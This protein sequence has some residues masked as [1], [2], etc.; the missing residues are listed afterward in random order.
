MQDPR[1]AIGTSSSSLSHEQERNT[2]SLS[3]PTIDSV[4]DPVD[5]TLT[6]NATHSSAI[7][8]HTSTK[9]THNN[10]NNNDEQVQHITPSDEK[11][12][13]PLGVPGTNS[14]DPNQDKTTQP[15]VASKRPQLLV[16]PNGAV[17]QVLAAAATDTDTDADADAGTSSEC[18]QPH[19]NS[20]VI[21]SEREAEAKKAAEA[22]VAAAIGD[23]KE[24]GH[25]R[26]KYSMKLQTGSILI[27][28]VQ[29]AGDTFHDIEF[30]AP[31][32]DEFFDGTDP[33]NDSS[34]GPSSAR[35]A[36]PD[37]SGDSRRMKSLSPGPSVAFDDY[38]ISAGATNITANSQNPDASDDFASRK[39]AASRASVRRIR[40]GASFMRAQSAFTRTIFERGTIFFRDLNL[41]T[42]FRRRLLRHARVKS[43]WMCMMLTLVMVIALATDVGMYHDE[44]SEITL[45]IA[46][47]STYL[48]CVAITF[49]LAR[50]GSV[51]RTDR[52][53]HAIH[54]REFVVYSIALLICGCLVAVYTIAPADSLN[55]MIIPSCFI[56]YLVV[57]HL[58]SKLLFP[59]LMAST[60]LSVVFFCAHA[61][62]HQPS[63]D[64]DWNVTAQCLFVVVVNGVLSY[65]SHDF[66]IYRRRSYVLRKAMEHERQVL[67]EEAYELREEV[68]NLVLEKFDIPADEAHGGDVDLQSPVEKAMLILMDLSRDESVSHIVSSQLKKVITYLG[69]SNDIFR[70]Q[71][72]EEIQDKHLHLDADTHH[73]LQ[74]LLDTDQER[75]RQSV[76]QRENGSPYGSTSSPAQPKNK[77]RTK[78]TFLATMMDD[79][80]KK[81]LE[82][83]ESLD[84]WDFDVFELCDLT[85]QRPLLFVGVALMKKYNLLETFDIPSRAVQNFF[86][87][88]EDGYRDNPYHNRIHAADVAQTLHYFLQFDRS[89]MQFTSLEI[90]AAIVAAAVHDYDHPGRNNNFFINTQHELALTYNDRSVLENHHVAAA[91]KILVKPENNLLVNCP[92]QMVEFRKTVVDMVLSTDLGQHFDFLGH[93]KNSMNTGTLDASVAKDRLV[94]LKMMIKCA[95]VSH[96]AKQHKLH[97]AWTNRI[98]EEFYQ[99]GDEER[100]LGIAVSPFMDRTKPNVP[101]AQ[102]GFINFLVKPM[103]DVWAM[104]LGVDESEFTCLQ[105]LTQNREFWFTEASAAVDAESATSMTSNN[106][107]ALSDADNTLPRHNSMSSS[108]RIRHRMSTSADMQPTRSR[109]ATS[110]SVVSAASASPSLRSRTST[111]SHAANSASRS[112]SQD[113][114]KSRQHSRSSFGSRHTTPPSQVR[115]KD[116]GIVM[117]AES[118]VLP[119]SG[120]SD[121]MPLDTSAET[122]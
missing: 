102:I 11:H 70:P 53:S 8:T 2:L 115:R 110:A 86:A 81:F 46:L 19:T 66:E 25:H 79:N 43:A 35:R 30:Q 64:R 100:K 95:D 36:A 72:E 122:N 17:P 54:T 15:T 20:E 120:M 119:E 112:K 94:V 109:G 60:W 75:L 4:S 58:L 85:R 82:T 6:V 27:G 103:F 48:V 40:R 21:A 12:E 101:K 22:A 29:R 44:S 83:I 13:H 32:T 88:I 59:M 41:E 34:N 47:G 16:G 106:S 71:I 117:A 113:D 73:W 78:S 51:W 63:V 93:F 38:N 80:Q 10:N 52:N 49:G 1:G 57:V 74:D 18:T 67:R 68:Y 111:T 65:A 90:L 108:P 99:Q 28:D 61:V 69:S 33:E 39:R 56:A 23:N 26:H 5:N 104:Y 14:N 24:T 116:D 77:S 76:W 84:S 118:N 97:V 121:D 89:S 3:P 96:T 50:Y 7:I 105:R 62:L 31:E 98:V 45:K 91:F 55:I 42:G 37:Q 107:R 114:V 9:Q 92:D 87:V